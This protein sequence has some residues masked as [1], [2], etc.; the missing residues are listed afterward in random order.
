MS[1]E[2]SPASPPRLD[3]YGRRRLVQVVVMLVVYAVLYFVPAGRLDLPWSW[4][5]FGLSLLSLFVGGVYVIRRNPQV[6]NERGRPAEG[7][8]KWDKLFLLFYTPLVLGMFVVGGLDARFGWSVVPLWLRLLGALLV[9]FS[10]ALTYAAMAHNKFLSMY[11][12]VSQQR[13]HLVAS[14]G[15]YRWVRHPMYASFAPGYI[16]LSFLFGSWWVLLLVGLALILVIYRTAMEDRTLQAELP[17]YADYARQV[18]WR[19][20]PGIW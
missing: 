12:Q 8:K 9:A 13:G 1:A 3:A 19:L 14:S 2:N 7:Q 11:V 18:R 6:I 20:I 10:A 17:G 4:A 15:P 5:Y 16:G